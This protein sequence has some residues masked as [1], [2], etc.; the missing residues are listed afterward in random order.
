MNENE[1]LKKEE[2]LSTITSLFVFGKLIK[3]KIM[4]YKNIQELKSDFTKGKIM[5][6][7]KDITIDGIKYD[8]LNSTEYELDEVLGDK[9]RK[10]MAIYNLNKNKDNVEK[11]DEKHTSSDD[12]KS[13]QDRVVLVWANTRMNIR[14]VEVKFVPKQRMGQV[15]VKEAEIADERIIKHKIPITL[16]GFNGGNAINAKVDTGAAVCSL[17]ANNVDI[18]RDSGL[19]SFSF[20]D[21]NVTMPLVDTQAVK[22]ADNGVENR[23]VVSFY[24]TIPNEDQNKQ[25]RVIKKVDFNLNDRS[26]MPD[27]ILLGQNFIKAGDFVVMGKNEE[28]KVIESDDDIDWEALQVMFEDVETDEFITIS[29]EDLN[30]AMRLMA[31]FAEL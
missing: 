20:G 30:E 26:G 22:T 9:K 12:E 6:L 29:K 7:P 28:N 25:N 8:F 23:P 21:R 11:Y 15:M 16:S 27:K 24:V 13:F 19:V 3:D 17:D 4:T 10:P 14:P 5:S 1:K 31:E 18:N 2:D